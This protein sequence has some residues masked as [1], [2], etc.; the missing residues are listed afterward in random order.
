ML[1][2]LVIVLNWYQQVTSTKKKKVKSAKKSASS[3]HRKLTTELYPHNIINTSWKKTYIVV[4]VTQK[5][6]YTLTW[7]EKVSGSYVIDWLI[8]VAV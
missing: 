5:T 2:N 3:G 4:P 7:Q 6:L 1:S 8:A